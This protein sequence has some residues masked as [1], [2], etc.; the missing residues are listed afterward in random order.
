MRTLIAVLLGYLLGCSSMAL[1]LSRWK[2]TD[3]TTHGTGNLGASNAMVVFGWKA[4]ALVA[5]HDIG[6]GFLAVWLAGKICPG[7]PVVQAATGVA[8]VMGHIFPFYNHFRGGKGLAAYLGMALAMDWRAALALAA[9]LVIITLVTDY[10][11]IGTMTTVAMA[12]AHFAGKE[13]SAVILLILL[14]AALVM[15]WKHRENFMRL[16]NGTEIGL[17]RANRGDYREN[18]GKQ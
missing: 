2:N 10:I 12:P 14:V 5:L 16:K 3:L 17:R 8:C 18:K 7:L 11:V 13:H 15:A 6:K 1:Y 4:G 9:L